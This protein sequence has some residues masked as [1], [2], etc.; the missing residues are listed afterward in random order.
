MT[1]RA[2]APKGCII[3]SIA[4]VVFCGPIVPGKLFCTVCPA[5]IPDRCPAVCSPETSWTHK[6][7]L[8]V[9]CPCFQILTPE[10]LRAFLG[11]VAYQ[12]ELA[13]DPSPVR[14]RDMLKGATHVTTGKS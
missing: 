5:R 8:T 14:L 6:C 2:D 9:G 11:W 13:G 1:R 10:R 7:T 12:R 4:T 3:A